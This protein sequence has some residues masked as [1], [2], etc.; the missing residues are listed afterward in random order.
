MV[1][2]LCQYYCAEVKERLGSNILTIYYA[3]YM[4]PAIRAIYILHC[5]HY[6]TVQLAVSNT[7]KYIATQKP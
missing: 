4:S 6:R 3:I 1:L 2:D 5:G 7:M